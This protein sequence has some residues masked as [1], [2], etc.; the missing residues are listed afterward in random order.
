MTRY[1]TTEK[2]YKCPKCD[3]LFTLREAIPLPRSVRACPCCENSIFKFDWF[4]LCWGDKR[5]WA[6]PI[7][8]NAPPLRDSSGWMVW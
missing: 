5:E 3:T 7:S 8:E 1:A 4:G 6:V 2:Q